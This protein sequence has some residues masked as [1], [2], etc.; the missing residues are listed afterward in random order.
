[1]QAFVYGVRVYN[2]SKD[3]GF[4]AQSSGE[5]ELAGLH[6]GA[7][8]G[9]WI[10]NAWFE[11]YGEWLPI[12]LETD[13]AAAKGMAQRKGCGRVRHLDTRQIYI[14]ELSN[15]ERVTIEETSA[16]TNTADA[17]AKTV[18]K[19]TF[20]RLQELLNL[21]RRL[22]DG[23][24]EVLRPASRTVAGPPATVTAALAALVAALQPTTSKGSREGPETAN[25]SYTLSV[26]D[27]NMSWA[28]MLFMLAAAVIG[29]FLT[30]VKTAKAME[31]D[32][33]RDTRSEYV[34]PAP[35]ISTQHVAIQTMGGLSGPH[36][37]DAVRRLLPPRSLLSWAAE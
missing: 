12:V 16:H 28:L 9:I 18:S 36:L 23:S 33:S 7:L 21:R 3:Q 22:P 15:S 26:G 10:Q 13:A 19:D 17:G 37:R 1:M 25:T 6:R 29:I 14:Q 35:V 32:R 30:G 24:L 31:K 8:T 34:P 4:M 20:Y 27:G 5:A 2:S 11:L